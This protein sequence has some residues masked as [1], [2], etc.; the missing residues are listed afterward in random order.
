MRGNII[1]LVSV[2]RPLLR[3]SYTCKTIGQ[4]LVSALGITTITCV[5]LNLEGMLGSTSTYES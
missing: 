5:L 4:F 2:Y 3:T 1:G